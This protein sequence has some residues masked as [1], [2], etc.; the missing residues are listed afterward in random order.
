MSEED[1]VPGLDAMLGSGVPG[2]AIAFYG[3]W[4]QLETWLREMV[5]VELRSDTGCSWTDELDKIAHRRAETERRNFY[6]ASADSEELLAYADITALFGI[7]ESRWDLFDAF[8]PPRRRWEGAAD[9]LSELRN[10]NAHCRRPHQ[11]D[12]PRLEQALR[13]LEAGAWRFYTSYLDTHPI[14]TKSKDPVARQ[15][16]KGRHDTA[17]R[18][19]DH[20][21]RQYE[22]RFR[23]S[24]SLRPW[25]THPTVDAISSTAGALWHA[26]WVIGARE[27]NV[28]R[29]WKQI[30]R[31]PAA[32]DLIVHLLFD[33]S[34][35]T[36]TFAAV[37][38]PNAI[39]D[40]I[41]HLFDA[42]LIASTPARPSVDP[43]TWADGW[44]RG[45]ELLPQCVQVNTP[46]TLVD[47]YAPNA[48][49]IFAA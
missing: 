33:L 20:A 5:Y 12:L 10:R 37:D 21:E 45:A 39:A 43:A 17:A 32:R 1:R 35:V 28:A 34:S 15:W 31:S 42:I 49:S 23:L 3:R 13:N 4:W 11:D 18:L 36:A 16:V 41:G 2:E 47:P 30:E 9:E 48:F 24:Y 27:L 14:T 6:M 44:I 7:I 8:L 25:A 26:Q 46:L 40:A 19:L 22:T 38:D 29:L